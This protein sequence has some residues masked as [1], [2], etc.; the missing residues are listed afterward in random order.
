MISVI[1]PCFNASKTLE[2]AYQSIP[3]SDETDL[4]LEII[5]ADDGSTDE[6]QNL[7]KS[8][9]KDDG[10]VRVLSNKKNVGVSETRNKALKEARGE[11]IFFMD[12]D[13]KLRPGALETLMKAMVDGV[14][15]V[16]AKHYLWD[17]V[18]GDCTE[19]IGEERNFSELYDIRPDQFPQVFAIYS[20]WNALFRKSLIESAGVRFSP[21]LKL[22]EDRMFNLNY[23]M[24][25]RKITLLNDY[26]YLWRKPVEETQQATRVLVKKPDS[27]F[28]SIRHFA[29][30]ADGKW[31]SENP[32]HR[33]VLASAMLVEMVNFL[34]SFS[35]EVDRGEFPKE[36]RQDIA[37]ILKKIRPEWIDLTLRGLK[38][39]T[40]VFFP[41]YEFAAA[42]AGGEPDDKFFKDFMIQLGKIRLSLAAQ[43]QP[44]EQTALPQY[45][46]VKT[47]LSRTFVTA[48]QGRPPDT[49]SLERS[50]IAGTNALDRE[51]YR[52]A[53]P[54][55]RDAGIDE[56]EHYLN[57]GAGE[58]RDPNQWFDTAHYFG[59]HPE[60]LLSGLNPLVH[61]LLTSSSQPS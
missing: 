17:P 30:L 9:A 23:L 59:E 8:L 33:R 11:Y 49:L 25:C 39:R 28:R 52:R 22:G 32:R 12:A 61:Y 21:D 56:L 60:L 7:L 34:T 38:G 26:T 6:T 41:L 13:D 19:N 14:D 58:L 1:I 20:S 35:R 5:F 40:E 37:V 31:L 2:E 43:A 36:A 42:N 10:R 54:D 55:V 51:Y 53:N 27:V 3:K 48:R 4:D 46:R 24:A 47:L 45:E 57:F 18:T 50:I 44:A 29:E 16:R 15:F